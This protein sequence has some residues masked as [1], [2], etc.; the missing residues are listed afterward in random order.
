MLAVSRISASWTA[1]GRAIDG[2]QFAGD[3]FHVFSCVHV[4]GQYGELVAFH[5]PHDI[6]LAYRAR[7]PE[8]Y[9]RQQQVANGIAMGL[10]QRFETIDV[11]QQQRRAVIA[12]SAAALYL[13][14]QQFHE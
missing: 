10:V 5:P 12:T 11:Q 3:D 4:H 13:V 6:G 9:F 14:L 1:N 8:R 2:E 7:Q